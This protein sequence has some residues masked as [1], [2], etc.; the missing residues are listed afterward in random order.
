MDLLHANIFNTSF[1]I[2]IKTPKDPI[3]D[4][5][6]ILREYAIANI[7]INKLRYIIPTFMYTFDYV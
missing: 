4:L 3:D 2:I 1:E 7:E 5:P 6:S